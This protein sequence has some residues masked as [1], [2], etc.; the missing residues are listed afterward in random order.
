MN[1]IITYAAIGTVLIITFL[2]W[3]FVPIWLVRRFSLNDKDKAEVED[4]Y[5]KTVGQAV[6]AVAIIVT[7]AWTF[8]KDNDTIKLTHKQFEAQTKQFSEQQT[9]ARQQF[10]NQQFI[11]AASLLKETSVGAR[12]AG[13]YGLYEVG[14]KQT[15]YGLPTV[16]AALGFIKSSHPSNSDDSW[17]T[18]EAD[19]QSAIGILSLLNSKHP[20]NLDFKEAYA[21]RG[22]FSSIGPTDAFAGGVFHGAKLYGANFSGLDVTGAHFDGSYMADWEAY[23]ER[24]WNALTREGYENT[25]WNYTVSF[26][27]AKLISAGFDNT[28]IAGGTFE[29]SCLGRAKF[30]RSDLS[31]ASFKNASLGLTATCDPN[32]GKAHFY[33]ATLIDA[34]FDGVDVGGVNFQEAIL[35]GTRFAKALNVDK[36]DFR[37][38]C[39]DDQTEFP[40]L[41]PIK[42]PRCTREINRIK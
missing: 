1:Y 41:N 8:T 39:G 2:F 34:S 25:R 29:D 33:Q 24:D 13:L 20:A 42:L 35:S 16:N 23:G 17:A 40:E 31:R 12:V 14:S 9:Q 36:A 4:N 18:V 15:Q 30:W 7:F 37:G 26:K 5:R 3:A 10:A 32:G 28:S 21:V 27:G 38:A 11:A 22:D 6:G 19:V